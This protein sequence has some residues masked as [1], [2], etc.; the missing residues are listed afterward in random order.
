MFIDLPTTYQR[1]TN[2]LSTTTT[3]VVD[4]A[5]IC[6]QN[7]YIMSPATPEATIKAIGLAFLRQ[8][9]RKKARKMIKLKIEN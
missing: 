5:C 3:V 2:D 1:P 9:R 7:E 4:K 8:E 6:P